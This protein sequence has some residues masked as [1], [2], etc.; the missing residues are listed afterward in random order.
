M[1]REASAE[2]AYAP[3]SSFNTALDTL[4]QHGLPDKLDR[5]AFNNQSGSTQAVL[6]SS[7]KAIGAINEEREVQP[8]LRRLVDKT[9]RK[10]ALNEIAQANYAS[11]IALGPAATMKQFDDAFT[12]LGVQGATRRKAQAFFLKLADEV[13]LK[14]STY[15]TGAKN[16][17]SSNAQPKAPRKKR[18][19]KGDDPPGGG[20][21]G[22][23]G[24]SSQQI[25]DGKALFHPAIDAF[26]R[27]ARKLTEQD[28]WN[29]EARDFVVQGFT[30]QL[31]LFL[32]V[33]G[34]TRTR[35]ES[36]SEEVE[37]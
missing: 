13:G 14:L 26:L 25:D 37:T 29:K 15:I 16:S 4:A 34:K 18:A 33:K 12:E 17:S 9:Q 7:L 11:I 23:G 1:A 22:G 32:P 27:E 20:T 10:E 21:P 2:V 31:D 8:L 19:R 24:G 6:M 30:T 35:K 28:S 5:T 36:A 3:F